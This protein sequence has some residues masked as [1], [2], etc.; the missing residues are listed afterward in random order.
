MGEFQQSVRKEV[1]PDRPEPTE[2]SPPIT[3]APDLPPKAAPRARKTNGQSWWKWEPPWIIRDVAVALYVGLL[4]F[5][6]QTLTEHNMK[7]SEERLERT[8]FE[9]QQRLDAVAYARDV[10]IATAGTETRKPFNGMDFTQMNLSG[11]ALQNADF[12]N[13]AKVAGTDLRAS[14]LQASRF[15]DATGDRAD[16]TGAE[17]QDSFFF[18]GSYVGAK[19]DSVT[20]TGTTFFGGDYKGADF[21]Q[22][23][24]KNVRFNQV[25]LSEAK[26]S[27]EEPYTICYSGVTW[28]KD[29]IPPPQGPDCDKPQDPGRYHP[30]PR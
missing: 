7:Q 29:F 3:E 24:V 27:F 2:M 5:G 9:L 8:R 15:I 30:D 10:S 16:F 1:F 26:L 28:P 25:D 21:T 11:L 23:I 18:F 22:A 12:I 13:G 19:F 6:M 20:L 4:I 14:R 17:M